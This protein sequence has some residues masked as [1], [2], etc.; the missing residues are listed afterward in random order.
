M[1]RKTHKLI[2]K[3]PRIALLIFGGLCLWY[4]CCL[5]NPLFDKGLSFVLESAD[6]TLLGAQIADDGQWRF[7]AQDSVPDK[8]ARAIITFE[9]KRFYRHPGVDLISLSRALRQNVTHKR[10]VS[11]GSTLSM[12]VIRMAMDNPPRTIVRKIQEMILATRLE[13]GYTK[14]EILNLY[15]ANAP[16]GGNV[17]GLEAASWRYFAKPPGLLSWAESCMLAVLPNSPALIH[18]GRNRSALKEKR[19]RLLRKLLERAHI[20]STTYSLA[21]EEPLPNAPHRL[22]RLAP[23]L[24]NRAKK[25][26][27]SGGFRLR[28]TIDAPLQRQLNELAALHL[29]QLQQNEIHNLGVLIIEVETG[30]TLAYLGNAPATGPAHAEAVDVLVAPRS[31]GSIL[32]PFLYAQALQDGIILPKSCLPDIPMQLGGYRPVN[33]YEDYDGMVAAE[34]AL[35]R[36]LNVPM[37]WLLQQ[38]GLE[39]FHHQLKEMGLSTIV[40]PPAHYGLPLILGGAEATVWD[41][42]GAYAKMARTLNHYPNN[43]ARYIQEDDKGAYYCLQEGPPASKTLQPQ[44]VFL[45]ASSIWFT[46]QAMQKVERPGIEG[47]WASFESSR[48]IAWKTGTSFGFRDAWAVG[49]NPQYAVGVWVGNADG[50]GRP[51]LV[52]ISAAAPLLF[53]VFNRLSGDDIWFEPPYDDMMKLEVCSL[54]GYRAGPYC[55]VDT[56]WS[57]ASGVRVAAC[58]FHQLIHVDEA[59]RWQVHKGCW[60]NIQSQ[61]HF[62]LPPVEEFYYKRKNPEY[63][64]LP[65]MHP[66]CLDESEGQSMQLIY[67]KYPTRIYVPTDLDGE[68]SKTIFKVAHRLPDITIHWHLDEFYVGS[69]TNFHSKELSPPVGKHLLT[70]VDANGSRLEQPFEIIGK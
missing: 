58:P 59:A 49:V 35:V 28:T 33:F 12:Q 2:K 17:V 27:A 8:F 11:G 9:D 22:P 68:Q 10:I 48:K 29:Q 44:A 19:N 60:D 32:K 56:L 13:L 54:S 52:G 16:F 42:T 5:P 46:F 18:P 69:T 61:A 31:T 26:S 7:P 43:S 20:D 30:K 50:E 70:L 15:A 66:D 65:P 21:L 3:Y 25:E 53:D 4:W 63:E 64:P 45:S 47:D 36:S 24:L 55:P 1:F 23:H 39:A 14:A 41:I 40:Y 67:P 37:I 6:G 57:P 51:G 34:K 62:V 38:Q